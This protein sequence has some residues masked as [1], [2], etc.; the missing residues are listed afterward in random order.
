MVHGIGHVLSGNTTG[1]AIAA[2]PISFYV[3]GLLAK[4]S[5]GSNTA[6]LAGEAVANAEIVTIALKDI[7]RR[8]R[9]G[10]VAP[11]PLLVV[12]GLS[13]SPS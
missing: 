10:D 3:G 1:L 13:W 4:D 12:H 2:V 9:P 6:L 7:T 8:L 11:T 5:Y